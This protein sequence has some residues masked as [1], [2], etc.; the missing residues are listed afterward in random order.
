M[1]GTDQELDNAN[2][3]ND[4][5]M[6]KEAEDRKLHRMAKVHN[7]LE[8][9]QGSQNICAKQKEFF[10]HNQLMTAGGYFLDTEEI[11]KHPGHSFNMMVRLHSNCQKDLHCHHLCRQRT[12]LE[13]EL[14][15]EISAES[16]ENT[17]MQW[18][19]T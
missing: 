11:V 4:S 15:S 14:K 13:D 7:F 6:N 16:R 18:P 8:M 5:E 9:W 1:A 12:S 17:V 10:P 3:E 2:T 19:V